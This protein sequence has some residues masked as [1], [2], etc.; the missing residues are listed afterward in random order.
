M[1][2]SSF[3]LLTV[4]L[5]VAAAW[6]GTANAQQPA[7]DRILVNGK[8][9]TVDRDFSIAQAVAISGER[10]PGRRHEPK[11]R[12]SGRSRHANYGPWRP[13]RHSGSDRQSRSLPAWRSDVAAGGP[14]RRGVLASDRSGVDCRQGACLGARPMGADNRRLERVSVCRCRA[15]VHQ[16]RT[17]PGRT[18]QSR[19]RS[20]GFR[21]WPGQQ[22][23]ARG[24]GDRS[25]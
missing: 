11:Y 15:I 20:S 10:I 3:L 1:T 25:Q 18:R 21:S 24:C 8:I 5:A 12:R 7:P 6:G 13:D 14:P 17:R 16:G 2:R 23:G 22:P 4:G 9:L 19:L